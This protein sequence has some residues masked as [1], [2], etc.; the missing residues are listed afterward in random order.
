MSDGR[1]TPPAAPGAS[2]VPGY[3]S[4]HA[5]VLF[6]TFNGIDTKS[7][8]PAVPDQ[9]MAW[10]RG[11]MPTG[12]SQLSI[13]PGKGPNVFTSISGIVWFQFGNIGTT[14]YAAILQSDG[15]MA[16]LDTTTGA[17]GFIMPP[18]T[19]QVPRPQMGFTQYGDQYFCFAKDQTNGYWLWDGTNLF[20]AGSLSPIVTLTSAGQ[21][22]TSAPAI[23][24]QTTGGGTGVAIQAQIDPGTQSVNQV[25]VTNPGSGYTAAP[26]VTLSGGGKA[27][28]P[29]VTATIVPTTVSAT[30]GTATFAN[31][32]I[33]KVGTYFLEVTSPGLTPTTVGP[34]TV[35]AADAA[36]GP[37]GSGRVR[38]RPR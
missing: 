25:T 11:F 15:S 32:N 31:L 19:I 24:I 17:S 26:P 9:M 1:V 2:Q 34:I 38:L 5:Q 3:P 30:N 18:G 4:S 37:A 6:E 29:T 22:Y 33:N 20:G 16:W 36:D 14:Y 27:S 23:N 7:P 35:T 10:C 12:P 13:L 28:P 8:R 21:N